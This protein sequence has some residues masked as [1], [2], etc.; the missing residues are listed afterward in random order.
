MIGFLS[1][2]WVGGWVSGP[3]LFVLSD[4]GLIAGEAE[5]LFIPF[6]YLFLLPSFPP[7]RSGFVVGEEKRVFPSFKRSLERWVG[8]WEGRF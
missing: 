4:G 6:L 2:G 3:Y 5:G 7:T 1:S 8:G